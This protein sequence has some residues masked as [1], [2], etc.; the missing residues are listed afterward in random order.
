[1]SSVLHSRTNETSNSRTN[2]ASS[3]SPTT[4]IPS[5]PPCNCISHLLD[6]DKRP[7]L[8]PHL[9]M[10]TSTRKSGDL[11][12]EINDLKH[13]LQEKDGIIEKQVLMVILHTG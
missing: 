8:A 4:S 2:R 11:E 1:M 10:K 5:S 7:K 3:S 9:P 6:I 13:A 12:N